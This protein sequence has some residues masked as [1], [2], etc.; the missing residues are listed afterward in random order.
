MPRRP[1][2]T[3]P[4]RTNAVLRRTTV[5]L[6]AAATVLLGS[7]SGG[8]PIDEPSLDDADRAACSALVK[9]LPE[10]VADQE[11][12]DVEPT[13]ALGA[14]WGDPAIVLTCG[15][16][17]PDGFDEAAGCTTVNDVDWYIPQEQLEGN[18]ETDLTMTTVLREQHV[19]VTLP[20]E[21]WPPATALV[22]LAAPVKET[23]ESAGTCF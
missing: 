10:K 5:T 8:V 20:G 9:A 3:S 13:D 18:G 14:A 22:D 23:I 11:R 7:C 2:L 15:V 17:A 19:E 21:Y 12:R 16:A 6:V 1:H 4:P